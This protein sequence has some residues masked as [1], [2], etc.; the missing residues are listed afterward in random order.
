MRVR[1]DDSKKDDPRERELG[2]VVF[3]SN[4]ASST[5]AL[6][7]EWVCAVWTPISARCNESVGESGAGGDYRD[8]RSRERSDLRG[9]W[10]KRSWHRNGGGVERLRRAFFA[11]KVIGNG[12]RALTGKASVTIMNST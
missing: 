3:R 9:W 12:F 7:P 11:W 4:T 1:F 6:I 10:R 8:E 5:A 2:S